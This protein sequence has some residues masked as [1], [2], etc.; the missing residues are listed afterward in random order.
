MKER[1]TFTQE[2]KD[3]AVA[4]ALEGS[5]SIPKVAAGLGLNPAVLRRWVKD[6]G[7]QPRPEKEEVEAEEDTGEDLAAES[8]AAFSEDHLAHAAKPRG[9]LTTAVEIIRREIDDKENDAASLRRALT[10][11]APRVEG[12]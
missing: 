7:Q 2:F 10:L 6:S 9:S 8:Q 3:D 11:L 1:R 5:L 12:K 4:K